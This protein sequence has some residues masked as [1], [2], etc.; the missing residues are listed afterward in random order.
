MDKSEDNPKQLRV[1]EY[2]VSVSAKYFPIVEHDLKQDESIA[3]AVYGQVVSIEDVSNQDGT[4]KRVFKVK[5]EIAQAVTREKN[6]SKVEEPVS[7]EPT[8]D[9]ILVGV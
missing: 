5:G 7:E 4:V 1:N 3:L 2:L 8:S 9:E 6:I